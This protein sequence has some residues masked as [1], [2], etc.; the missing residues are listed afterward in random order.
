MWAEREREG[1]LL[2]KEKL[3]EGWVHRK[4]TFPLDFQR[5]VLSRQWDI[6]LCRG[7]GGK[8]KLCNQNILSF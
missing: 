1:C 4:G 2:K 5:E 8:L 3:K 6:G 7:R